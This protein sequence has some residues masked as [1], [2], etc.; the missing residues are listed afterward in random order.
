MFS[1]GILYKIQPNMFLKVLGRYFKK[2]TSVPERPEIRE[3]SYFQISYGLRFLYKQ[4]KF[5]TT[6]C[7]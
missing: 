6:V 3:Y 2:I 4:L 5:L 7:I 1:N